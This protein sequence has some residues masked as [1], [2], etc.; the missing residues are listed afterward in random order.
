MS[1]AWDADYW[2]CCSWRLFVT[3]AC[4]AKTTE[5][6]HILFGVETPRDPR[7]IVSDWDFHLSVVRGRDFMY[8]LPNVFGYL[9]FSGAELVFLIILQFVYIMTNAV[10]CWVAQWLA[11]L[12]AAREVVSL[13][14]PCA[15]VVQRCVMAWAANNC[16]SCHVAVLGRL[17]T[18]RCGA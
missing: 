18:H 11:S 10:D 3:R 5:W 16:D 1:N 2:D 8:P 6:I 7:T 14:L 4:C 13:M 15:L 17:F 9:L 12:L